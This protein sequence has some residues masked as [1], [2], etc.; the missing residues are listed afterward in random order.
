ML[1]ILQ[2]LWYLLCCSF[3]LVHER[4][5]NKLKPIAVSAA[6]NAHTNKVIA[7]ILISFIVIAIIINKLLELIVVIS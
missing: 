4:S 1:F 2:R 6:P 7:N 3:F 5:I